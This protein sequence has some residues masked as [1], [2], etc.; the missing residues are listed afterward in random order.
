MGSAWMI[1]SEKLQGGRFGWLCVHASDKLIQCR[2]NFFQGQTQISWKLVNALKGA[3][4]GW[5]GWRGDILNKLINNFGQNTLEIISAF[6]FWNPTSFQKG[7]EEAQF[8]YQQ[9]S[10]GVIPVWRVL[11]AHLAW[12]EVL[13]LYSQTAWAELLTNLS[14]CWALWPQATYLTP[15]YIRCSHL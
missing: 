9:L 14:A 2:C 6:N 11:N 13:T 8:K 3:V 4:W 15:L 1:N 12:A 5:G 10:P 7:F